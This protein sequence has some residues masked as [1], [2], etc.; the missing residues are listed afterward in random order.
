[1]VYRPQT[2]VAIWQ[3]PWCQV[4]LSLFEKLNRPGKAYQ[5]LGDVTDLVGLRIITYLP[6]D[7]DGVAQIIEDEFAIDR[8]NSIDK[9][10]TSDPDR[11]GYAS[12]HKVC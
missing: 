4:T 8:V 2:V 9:R 7:V 12:L 6:E 10:L 1:M 5:E 11:F 3:I